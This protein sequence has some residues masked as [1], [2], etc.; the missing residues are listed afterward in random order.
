M[1]LYSFVVSVASE[2]WPSLIAL[3]SIPLLV[4]AVM[5]CFADARES[6][7]PVGRIWGILLLLAFAIVFPV[8][9]FR[10]HGIAGFKVLFF[11]IVFFC[12]VLLSLNSM[13]L[14]QLWLNR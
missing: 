12:L 2:V 6:E 7:H 10:T 9:V 14:I 4:M 13:S 1:L 8:Y 11:A 3:F 5:W